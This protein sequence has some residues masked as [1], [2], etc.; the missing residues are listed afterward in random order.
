LIT[1]KTVEHIV[2]AIIGSLV[3]FNF[4]LNINKVKND[5]INVIIKNWATHQYFFISFIWG[6]LGGHFFLGSPKP[7][8]GNNWWLPLLLLFAL[9]VILILLGR[10]LDRSFIIKRRYQFSLLIAGVLYGHFFW[11]QRHIPQISF[12]W[13]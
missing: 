7:V 5:T 6:V 4:Y 3:L 8:F 10:R 12:P 11:S 9:L 1:I 13:L 2:I